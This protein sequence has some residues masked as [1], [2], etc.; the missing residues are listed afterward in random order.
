[1]HSTYHVHH[2]NMER[3]GLRVMSPMGPACVSVCPAGVTSDMEAIEGVCARAN[4]RL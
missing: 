4:D 3:A 1:M 2:E